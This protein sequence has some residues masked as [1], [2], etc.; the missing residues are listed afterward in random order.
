M[1]H[2]R[3]FAFPN[4]SEV[5]RS[6]PLPP[7]RAVFFLAAGALAAVGSAQPQPPTEYL[8]ARFEIV[9]LDPNP[10]PENE[11]FTIV[12][13][14]INRIDRALVVRSTQKTEAIPD[15]RDF[16]L[17]SRQERIVELPGRFSLPGDRDVVVAMSWQTDKT[18]KKF[19]P[20][21]QIISVPVYS[22]LGEDA[23]AIAVYAKSRPP[24]QP[25]FF[26]LSPDQADSNGATF[27]GVV[28]TVVGAQDGLFAIP[29]T[30]GVWRSVNGKPWTYLP[31]SP[32]RAFSIAIDP[33]NSSR[34]AVGERA[35][36][37]PD[38]RLG[39]S[40]LWESSDFGNSWTYTYDPTPD[41]DSQQ[42]PAVTFA[43]TT[44]TLLI[45]TTRGVARKERSSTANP[46]E[47]TFAYGVPN[48][49]CPGLTALG[50]I[51]ALTASETRVWARSSTHIFFSDDDGKTWACRAFPPTVDIPSFPNLVADFNTT[52]IGGNDNAAIGAFDDRAFLIFKA[53]VPR[54]DPRASADSR[55]NPASPQN[56]PT[57]NLCELNNRSPLIIFDPA[58]SGSAAWTAQNT[59]DNDGRGLNGRRFVKTYS[60]DPLKCPAFANRAIGA[61]RQIAYGA[62]QGVQQA[63]SQAG[64]GRIVWDNVLLT[65]AGSYPQGI[66]TPVHS[67][68]WDFALPSDYCPPLKAKA[69]FV[70][71]GG[72]DEGEPAANT[73]ARWAS[74]TWSTRS[75]GLHVQTAQ[76]LLVVESSTVPAPIPGKPAIPILN[77][78]YPTQD[79]NG[80]WRKAD[81]N[82]LN[83][84]AGGDANYVAGDVAQPAAVIWRRLNVADDNQGRGWAKVIDANG[85]DTGIMLNRDQPLDG[86]TRIQAIQ[87]QASEKLGSG[88]LDMT[89]LV[90]LPLTKADGTAA[91]DPS[92]SSSTG[93][94]LALIRN[95][96]FEQKPDGPGSGFA[97]WTTELDALPQD[98]RRFWVAGGHTNP[99]YYFYTGGSNTACP[100]GLQVWGRASIGGK[101]AWRCLIS[102]LVDVPVGNDGVGLHGPAFVNPFDP[103]VIVVAASGSSGS[104]GTLK[105]SINAGKEFCDLP[106]L[107]ALMTESGRYPLV[108]VYAPNGTFDSLG[109]RFHGYPFSIPSHISFSRYSSSQFVVASPY[110]GLYEGHLSPVGQPK[111]SGSCT[112]PGWKEPRW[113]DLSPFMPGSRSYVSATAIIGDA[114]IVSTAGRGV[115]AISG[116]RL[117]RPASYF[118]TLAQARSSDV[119]ASLQTGDGDALPWAR[120]LVTIYER[121]TRTLKQNGVQVRTDGS[122]KLRL[123]FVLAQGKYV[124][125][126]KFVGDGSISPAIA[127]YSLEIIP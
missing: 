39:R 115:Y 34:L 42:I 67:D 121:D 33:N 20:S 122:G 3:F 100:N 76:D 114:A 58:K 48:A 93:T 120:V 63:L 124:V 113:M 88:T 13:R 98:T 41:A 66:Q 21:G 64:D 70:T 82:W 71:D 91:P 12:M 1:H 94:R 81:G 38:A 80:W 31:G 104:P 92:G 53:T 97:G 95:T 102:N 54:S 32:Q 72:I 78:A 27:S 119:I 90:Q 17:D 6:T 73:P 30:A 14:V 52:S 83:I 24:A 28:Q 29:K 112:D 89:M 111:V 10:V 105:I 7:M 101:F 87:S 123:P 85:T 116:M 45:A 79:N 8:P 25:S 107:T 86:P 50:R 22:P 16:T 36:D 59:G 46:F 37:N 69:F 55:C 18:I 109:S 11:T 103:N 117:P 5:P 75:Q 23:K 40:G 118:Q 127:K 62:G 106:G 4:S 110:T 99:R 2:R 49:G 51:T 68:V 108:G 96:H 19:L 35:D 77:I 44:S 56:I 65:G 57:F 60:I 125:D 74:M 15:T 43:R 84:S 61:G 47:G 126:L 26:D 9:K